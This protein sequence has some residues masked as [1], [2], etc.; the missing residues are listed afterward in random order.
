MMWTATWLSLDAASSFS[1]SYGTH[2]IKGQGLRAIA[3]P[4]LKT[5]GDRGF[6]NLQRSRIAFLQKGPYPPEGRIQTRCQKVCS[7][8]P[9]L[10]CLHQ[11]AVWRLKMKSTCITAPRHM[12]C[13]S[14]ISVHDACSQG[15]AERNIADRNLMVQTR[16]VECPA[17]AGS[18]TEWRGKPPPALKSCRNGCARLLNSVT[19]F[20]LFREVRSVTSFFIV[21]PSVAAG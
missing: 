20:S 7:C 3:L 8:Y 15:L 17:G 2:R 1:F 6:L 9:D 11:N 21:L 16:V 13:W 14:V 18:I 19:L 12:V 10:T 5:S 4:S